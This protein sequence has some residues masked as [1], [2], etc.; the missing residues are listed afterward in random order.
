M[1]GSSTNENWEVVPQSSLSARTQIKMTNK[2]LGVCVELPKRDGYVSYKLIPPYSPSL[3]EPNKEL[4]FIE[5]VGEIKS[6]K[7][8]V[9][10]Y[11]KSR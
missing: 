4:G 8:V 11:W 1:G 3:N 5:N 7:L 10:R 6:I 9:E 2:G